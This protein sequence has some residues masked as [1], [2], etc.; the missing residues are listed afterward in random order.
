MLKTSDVKVEKL[1]N[2]FAWQNGK[3]SE[4]NYF[5][6]FI[7]N[8]NTKNKFL[9]SDIFGD[10]YH[11]N[12]M[13]YLQVCWDGHL[14]VVFTPDILW[15]TILCELA[16]IVKENP[17][18]YRH[19]FTNSP[20]RQEISVFSD[21]DTVMPLDSLSK[22]LSNTIP[23]DSTAFLP[24]FTTSSKRSQ[25]AFQLCFCDMASPYY[26]YSMYCCGIPYVDVRGSKDDYIKIISNLENIAKLFVFSSS[27]EIV[28]YFKRLIS[29][30][31]EILENLESPEFWSNIFFLQR[32]GSG[33]DVEAYGWWTRLFLKTPSV[34]YVYNYSTH[35]S[36]IEYTNLNTQKQYVMSGGLVVSN[37]QGDF[38]VP[39]FGNLVFAKSL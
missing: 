27:G 1:K 10:V 18:G 17:D 6:Y 7:K 22:S 3:Y 39:D 26:D 31:Q 14:G 16:Q 25:S 11:R 19:L 33:S 15:Y 9:S 35:L 4:I 32:C 8:L 5:D 38:L 12:Y 20:E 21:S 2:K 24:E 13:E 23:S 30:T 37:M 36:S 28:K 34:K 29:L